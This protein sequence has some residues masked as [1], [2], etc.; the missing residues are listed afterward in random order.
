MKTFFITDKSLILGVTASGIY[1]SLCAQQGFY[2]TA[3]KLT[4]CP[5]APATL[6]EYAA[7]CYQKL[8]R[9]MTKCKT[10]AQFTKLHLAF[11]KRMHHLNPEFLNA[12]NGFGR[13]VFED[14]NDAELQVAAHTAGAGQTPSLA[15]ILDQDTLNASQRRKLIRFLRQAKYA[16]LQIDFND[17][18][19]GSDDLV[20][21]ENGMLLNA[22]EI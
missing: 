2:M 3:N 19:V 7:L 1:E 12:T 22:N 11:R 14:C 4:K 8:A 17:R 16:M 9:H 20:D 18:R 21:F 5:L 6:R 13:I 15:R 10:D